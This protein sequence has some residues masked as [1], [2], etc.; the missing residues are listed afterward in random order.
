MSGCEGMKK[1]G[2]PKMVVQKSFQ[3]FSS[4]AAALS[5]TVFSAAQGFPGR[6]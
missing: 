4:P 1:T 3:P 5:L 6:Q 2:L